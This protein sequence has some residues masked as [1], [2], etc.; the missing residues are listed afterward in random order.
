MQMLDISGFLKKHVKKCLFVGG[1]IVAASLLYIRPPMTQE[2]H[3]DERAVDNWARLVLEDQR[4]LKI[5]GNNTKIRVER[6]KERLDRADTQLDVFRQKTS[7]YSFMLNSYEERD[8]VFEIMLCC[9]QVS[10]VKEEFEDVKGQ[11]V[12]LR[13]IL[14]RTNSVNRVIQSLEEEKA[15]QV[16]PVLVSAIDQNISERRANLERLLSLQ[17]PLQNFADKVVRVGI[18]VDELYER[19]NK[20]REVAL[21]DMFLTRNM[22]LRR[23]WFSFVRYMPLWQVKISS[24]WRTQIPLTAEFWLRFLV[25]FSLLASLLTFVKVRWIKPFLK[26]SAM[27][28]SDPAALI[29]FSLGYWLLIIAAVFGVSVLSG[30]L[31]AGAAN[32]FIQVFQAS[33]STGILLISMLMRNQTSRG[34]SGVVRVVIPVI[35]QHLICAS[36]Y[37]TLV[38]RNPLLVILPVLNVVVAVWLIYC[39]LKERHDTFT[40]CLGALTIAQA[41]IS[42]WL[43]LSGFVYFAFT[44]TLGWQ[45]LIAQ[46]LLAFVITVNIYHLVAQGRARR[47][48]NI[49]LRRLV[50]PLVWVALVV[51]LFFWLTQTYH[52]QDYFEALFS[53][54][55]PMTEVAVIS[56][57]RVFVIA[58]LALF[59]Q[60]AIKFIAVNIQS[61]VQQQQADVQ[62][63][64]YASALTIGRYLSWTGFVIVACVICQVN[65]KSMLVMLGGLGLGLGLALKGIAENFFSGITLL[66]GQ[67]IR[68]GDL[69][70]IGNN[71]FATVQKITFGRTIVET[72]DGAVVTYPNAVVTSKEFRNWTRHDRCRRYDI[73]VDIAYGTDLI[74]VRGLLLKAVSEQPGI[75]RD[76]VRQPVVMISGFKDSSVGFL[77]RVWIEMPVYAEIST[78]LQVRIYTMLGEKQISIPFPQMDVHLTL[79]PKQETEHPPQK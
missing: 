7:V 1:W 18:L 17:A 4:Y 54:P 27:L 20:K 29:L 66:V 3:E 36:L 53:M 31:S 43:A 52:L 39:L 68:P 78:Q 72:T 57:N 48:R 71:Q 45:V 12:R 24:W 21:Q 62:G 60:F 70:E 55:L 41:L 67:E 56:M 50:L 9:R 64:L 47:L 22:D 11:V 6:A 23:A 5:V 79:P 35:I 40:F 15:R 13:D 73:P 58:S 8:D 46:V 30:W 63:A 77:V 51:S 10:A 34:T 42:I 26:R 44:M 65:A 37:I 49:V 76:G 59:L 75:E 25:L 16:S 19:S 61:R 69:V 38:A 2:T 14:S 33:S 74:A 32:V 28:S